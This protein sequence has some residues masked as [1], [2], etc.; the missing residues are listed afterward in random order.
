MLQTHPL[1]N[2][3][4]PQLLRLPLGPNTTCIEHMVWLRH[5]FMKDLLFG[6][7]GRLLVK[8][9]QRVQTE[10]VELSLPQVRFLISA[11]APVAAAAALAEP[12]E[13]DADLKRSAQVAGA[14]GG[15]EAAKVTR[16]GGA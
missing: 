14:E 3:G 9:A 6:L 1:T 5:R 4:A 11:E 8:E 12:M 15:E 7:T 16:A 10:E 2:L 13:I